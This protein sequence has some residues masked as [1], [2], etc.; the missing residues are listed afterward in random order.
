MT[1]Q[2]MELY[3][4]VLPMDIRAILYVVQEQSLEDQWH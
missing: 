1:S 2:L 3:V 4:V